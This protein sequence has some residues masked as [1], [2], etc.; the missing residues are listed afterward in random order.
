MTGHAAACLTQGKESLEG[1]REDVDGGQVRLSRGVGPGGG[2]V[3]DY[4]YPVELMT[5]RLGGMAARKRPIGRKA[6]SAFRKPL[7]PSLVCLR[8]VQCR[9]GHGYGLMCRD[10]IA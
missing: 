10:V 6:A 7:K 2:R 9:L 8:Y 1:V 3:T 4:T 5:M